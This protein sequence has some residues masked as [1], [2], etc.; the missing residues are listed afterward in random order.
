MAVDI[1][2]DTVQYFAL[3][4]QRGS[5]QLVNR[6]RFIQGQRVLKAEAVHGEQALHQE[7][8]GHRP[9]VQ[10]FTLSLQDN[11]GQ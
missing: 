8:R 5:A 3:G 1:G 2:I 7:G 6:I 10:G 11:A 9:V 4:C